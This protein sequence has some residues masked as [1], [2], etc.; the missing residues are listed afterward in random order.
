MVTSQHITFNVIAVLITLQTAV[1]LL[2]VRE[3]PSLPTPAASDA[4]STNS[5]DVG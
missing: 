3:P 1:T 2:S 4:A 5:D